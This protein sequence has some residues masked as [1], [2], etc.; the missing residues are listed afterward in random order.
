MIEVRR[1]GRQAE[2]DRPAALPDR[3][4][5]HPDL[6]GL[7]RVVGDA[8]DLEEIDSP[9]GVEADRGIVE[10]LASGIVADAPIAVVP[11]AGVGSIGRVRRV[12]IASGDRRVLLDRA[13]RNS[14]HDV[15]SELQSLAVNPVGERLEPRASGCRGEAVER[16]DQ[17]S[18]RR[19]SGN[20][21]RPDPCRSGRP[22]TNPC[23]PRHIASHIS[24]ATKALWR[25]RG[26]R[27]RRSSARR[28]PSCSSP[29]A[30]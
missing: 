16:R 13:A 9:A 2:H 29:S 14:T 4:R 6:R 19:R 5:D 7:V 28:N 17:P 11:A 18:V 24:S 30:G 23:R 8:I 10:G 15:N 3:G 26:S 21:A 22:C 25:W 20:R 12:K 27:P 1:T